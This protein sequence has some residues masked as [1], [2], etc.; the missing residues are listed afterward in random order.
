MTTA[1]L[2][3]NRNLAAADQA[4]QCQF[5]DE[6]LSSPATTCPARQPEIF[7]VPSRYAMA[8]QAA[9]HADF[10]PSSP[11]KSHPMAL[12]R[13]RAG[14]VYLWHA[15]GPLKR[16]A[17]ASDGLLVEQPLTQPHSAL[18][19][20][21][22]AGIALNK[23]TDA[24]MLYSEVP[25]GKD[26]C[27]RLKKNGERRKRMRQ[28]ALTDVAKRLSA[29]H[30]P[31]LEKA[32]TL[33]AEL[34][35]KVREKTLAYEHQKN[36]A[37]DREGVK[38][39]R[40]TAQASPTQDNIKAY[41]ASS[42]SLREREQAAGTQPPGEAVVE[43]GTWSATPW[44]LAPTQVWLDKAKSESALLYAVFAALDDDL[45]VL[46]DID[47][48]QNKV[49]AE[50]EEW[51][52][53]NSLRQTIGSF[54]RNM[55]TEDGGEVANLLN[56]RYRE[57]NLQLTPE[58]GDTLI[59]SQKQLNTLMLEET[60]INQQRGRQYGHAQADGLLAEVRS[61]EEAVLNKVRS[62]IPS[63]LHQEAQQVVRDYRQEKVSNLE[64]GGGTKVGE[65]IDLA[66]M[67]H[68]LDQE[69]P[70][71]FKQVEK[72]HQLL[73]A[74]RK[75]YLP[76]NDSGTWFVDQSS[77][78]H[79]TW[80]ESLTV[81]C[82]SAQCSRSEGAK[83]F[84]D[85]VSSDDPGLLR[86]VFQAWSPSLEAAVNNTSRLNELVTALSLE[87]LA[88]SRAAALKILDADTLRNIERLTSNLE[89]AWTATMTRL[90]ASLIHA[91]KG[92]AMAMGLF[93]VIRLGDNTRLVQGVEN[94][95]K[96][97]RLV[98]KNAEALGQWTRSTAQAISLGRVNGIVNAPSIKASGGLLPLAALVVNI[99]NAGT[100][101]GQAAALEGSDAQRHADSMSAYLYAGAALGAVIQ[102]WM[103]LGKG[104]NEVSLAKG[105]LS[106]TAP[107]LTLFGAIVGGLSGFAAYN[108]WNSL[109][110][111]IESAQEN[112]DP[113]LRLKQVAVT[114]Q[115]AV[116]F[117]QGLLG[118]SLT[119]LRL[120]NTI[121]TPIAIRRFRLGMGPLNLLLVA[122]GG[123][124][125]FAWFRQASPL[126]SYLANCCWSHR[127]A[128]T[129]K[130]IAPQAQQ[131][132][133][134]ELMIL[135]YQPRLAMETREVRIGG[136]LGDTITQDGIC[137]LTIDLPGAAPG[138]AQIDLAMSGNLTPVSAG[139]GTGTRG[140][141]TDLGATWLNA[142]ECNWIP[143]DAG[144]GLRLSG[145]F[146][147]PLTRL[148]LRLCYL[149]PV[150]LLAGV[151]ATIGGAKGVAYT[152]SPN[153]GLLSPDGEI[154]TLRS[155]EP[156]PEL[157][158]A[159][160]HRLGPQ[161]NS[162][163]LTPKEKV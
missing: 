2:D 140:T 59:D 57:H 153:G 135:L 74:D 26:V 160:V 152:L 13:L 28:I 86:L 63:E 143:V 130:D 157:D 93:L 80:L 141:P 149:S 107:T 134:N 95:I 66:S 159:I 89:G 53:D 73:Y 97:W 100:Y 114:G 8:E 75:N 125:L 72:R 96:V 54:I 148:S 132:E 36:G 124:Y 129:N 65:Y 88:D 154:I 17:V 55:V 71:H 41:S 64:G 99:L 23:S 102:N 131:D 67:D 24:W 52:A 146:P 33:V 48:E 110:S 147:Q 10:A 31:P 44:E 1:P 109:N 27:E 163:Y 119:S 144:Q 87:N 6:E 121:S 118:L 84:A 116:Y 46:R 30:C 58:Q 38:E 3:K 161:Q 40:K 126:Q 150:A 11:T 133:I 22:N 5:G 29:K 113:W 69:A 91:S 78:E 50:H 61:R 115:V 145:S 120:A 49:E 4:A 98:G 139:F 12:R 42:E 47:H 34:M 117:A 56:Y 112:V 16:Y 9:E 32:P 70:Q 18:T 62:F 123:L 83:Q 138:A 127:R 85:Y 128:K 122:L 156:T 79:L 155:G 137:Q 39:Q 111:Q 7:V 76:R 51:V 81:A 158:R 108:E 82:L 37:T 104:M 60:R 101:A 43:P 25:L 21:E 90:G 15:E 162:S 103:I 35:P 68:W 92:T 19:T 142:T 94:G 105:Q 151:G 14:Y 106:F 136:S 77:E 45:G 20:G